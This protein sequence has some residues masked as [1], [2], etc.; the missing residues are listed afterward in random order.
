MRVEV[1]DVRFPV[2]GFRVS[3]IGVAVNGLGVEMH[4]STVGCALSEVL[5]LSHT[6]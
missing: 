1:S 4:G 3:G 2:P 5:D 6:R